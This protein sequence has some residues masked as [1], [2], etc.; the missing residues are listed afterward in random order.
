MSD[1]LD[2]DRA[3]PIIITSIIVITSIIITVAVF[4]SSKEHA[5]DRIQFHG[6]FRVLLRPDSLERL[7]RG[8]PHKH[9]C[10][11]KLQPNLFQFGGKVETCL[12][13][14][15]ENIRFLFLVVAIS[16]AISVVFAIAI[17]ILFFVFL[18]HLFAEK[19]Q[20]VRAFLRRYFPGSST[21]FRWTG[22]PSFS[23]PNATNLQLLPYATAVPTNEIFVGKLVREAGTSHPHGLDD[24][25]APQLFDNRCSIVVIL[26]QLVVGFETTNIV[27]RH[28]VDFL[29]QMT[30]LSS[31]FT[32]DRFFGL[33]RFVSW[34]FRRSV[35]VFLAG[36]NDTRQ[37]PNERIAAVLEQFRGFFWQFV[38]I[39]FDKIVRA[40]FDRARIVVDREFQQRALCSVRTEANVALAIAVEGERKTL[41]AGT[42]GFALVVENAQ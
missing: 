38:S 25:S 2:T 31:K 17:A 5:K 16:V 15:L 8:V 13:F 24:A 35:G 3:V 12:F 26:N 6:G 33:A 29:S 21:L 40:V 18:L 30:Q 32:P 36:P 41:V 23:W 34:G 37:L 39:F 11:A 10:L 14:F 4:H 20:Q 9:F 27:R 7:E 22:S 28:V 1:V 19:F 42:R